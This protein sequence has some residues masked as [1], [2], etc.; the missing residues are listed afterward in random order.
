MASLDGLTSGASV[1]ISISD[2]VAG[3]I[4]LGKIVSFTHKEDASIPGKPLMDGTILIPKFREGYS[5]N[6]TAERTNNAFD[7]YTSIQDER[8]YNGLDETLCTMIVTI[9]EL[10]GA[11]TQL[12]FIETQLVATHLGDYQGQDTVRFEISFKSRFRKVTA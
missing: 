10:N 11:L 4:D 9:S 8:Y 12:T 7:L 5:G 3:I 2:P 6:I 1:R